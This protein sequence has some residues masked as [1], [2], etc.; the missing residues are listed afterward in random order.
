MFEYVIFC[1]I[2]A[3]SFWLFWLLAGRDHETRNYS[4]EEVHYHMAEKLAKACSST[5]VDFVLF[6]Y[7]HVDVLN[8][9]SLTVI[10]LSLFNF[11]T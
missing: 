9:C 1:L 11:L 5:F 4:F 3:Y 6:V 10:M 2:I 8:Y 7:H